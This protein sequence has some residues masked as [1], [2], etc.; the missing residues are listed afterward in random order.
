LGIVEM[1]G[2]ANSGNRNGRNNLTDKV[3]KAMTRAIKQGD[4]GIN[5]QRALSD[6]L[7]Q[8]MQED[9]A[10]F[11]QI[12]GPFIPK[13]VILDQSISI[14]VALEEARQRVIEGQVIDSPQ[15]IEHQPTVSLS[16]VD[17]S[18]AVIVDSSQGEA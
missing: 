10:R 18:D 11:I 9:V 6:L 8:L 12:T 3:R 14:T 2:N 7:A 4:E 17:L 13:E 5:G 16:P 1:A 15:L